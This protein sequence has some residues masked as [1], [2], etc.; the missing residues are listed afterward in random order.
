M[1]YSVSYMIVDLLAGL[2][3]EWVPRLALQCVAGPLAGCTATIITNPF[4]VSRTR[5]QVG[6]TY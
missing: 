2:S 1:M 4:D 6:L 3:P 5:V